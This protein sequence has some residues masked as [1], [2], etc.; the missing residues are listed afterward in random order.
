MRLMSA[1]L[2][3]GLLGLTPALAFDDETQMVLDHMKHG[4]L[5]PISDVQ[6]LM[7]QSERWCYAQDEGACSWSDIYLQVS[8]KSATFEINSAWDDTYDL[9]STQH[10]VFRD[11][12]YICEVEENWV[13]TARATRRSDGEVLGGRDLWAFK[14]DVALAISQ[15]SDCFDY[16]LQRSDAEAETITLLQ[17]K[18]TD[19]VTDPI[20]DVTVTVHFNAETAA[21]LVLHWIY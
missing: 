10:G 18:Y 2:V 11:G 4:K 20:D 5:M 14:A 12:R 19:G 17:R 8:G 13:P 3:V 16:V 6:V 1:V 21:G 7:R 9:A 15:T